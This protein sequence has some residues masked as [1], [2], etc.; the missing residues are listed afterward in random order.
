MAISKSDI[1][2]LFMIGLYGTELETSNMDVL[3]EIKPGFVIFFSRNVETPEKFLKFTEDISNFLGYRPVFAIDQEGGNVT[4]LREG[5]TVL[6]SHMACTATNDPEL[7]YNGVSVMAKEMKAVG[8][9]WNLAPVVDV[10]R[11]PYNPVIGIRS[12]SD[13]AL[14]VIKYGTIFAYACENAG[15]K[16]CLKHFPGLGDVFID[17]HFSLPVVRKGYNEMFNEDLPPFLGINCDSWMPTH[18]NFPLF[19]DDNLPASLSKK[20]LTT[21]AR[22]MLSY[23]GLLVADDLLMGGVSEFDVTQRLKLSFEAGMDVLTICHEPETQLKAFNQFVEWVL[24]DEDAKKRLYESLNRVNEFT[25]KIKNERPPLS[26]VGSNE[27]REL[28]QKLYE[29]SVTVVNSERLQLPVENIDYIITMLAPPGSPVNENDLNA[30]PHLAKKL[31]ERYCSEILILTDKTNL[32]VHN[33]K[34]KRIIL[35]SFDAYKNN[36][37]KRYIIELDKVSNLIIIAMR[38]PYDALLCKNSIVTFGALEG[39]QNAVY[40]VLSGKI[41]PLGVLPFNK[42]KAEKEVIR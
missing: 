19:Q 33:Y 17:P 15:I 10:N 13:I 34:G 6:P 2:K 1:G 42:S 9:D 29:K 12:F 40:D 14:Y 20:I 24:T 37:L 21:L 7:V 41:K 11:N 31:A 26:I 35:I 36:L 28:M 27:H 23:D 22:E 25:H 8:I 4:R 32:N 5:F 39:Q 38:N 16:T 3:K 18:V 30:V